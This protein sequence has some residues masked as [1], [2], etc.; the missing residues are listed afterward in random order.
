MVITSTDLFGRLQ[1]DRFCLASRSN[2][3]NPY[4]V[5]VVDRCHCWSCMRMR[6][7]A[8]VCLRA[9]PLK[10]RG[11]NFHECLQIREIRESFLPRKFLAIRYPNKCM[12]FLWIAALQK[13]TTNASCKLPLLYAMTIPIIAVYDVSRS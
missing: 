9:T 11:E 3:H 1:L 7:L 5:A 12:H 13:I 6:K 8:R 2:T 10:I 4:A